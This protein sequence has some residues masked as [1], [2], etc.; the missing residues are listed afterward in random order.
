[1]AIQ[2]GLIGSE[3]GVRPYRVLGLH[4]QTD[5]EAFWTDAAVRQATAQFKK[6]QVD[7]ADPNSA[8][9]ATKHE[10]KQL[11]NE[12][13]Q[14]ADLRE[15]MEQAGQQTPSPEGQLE[16]LDELRSQRKQTD[17]TPSEIEQ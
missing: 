6:E 5:L 12:Q 14:R 17:N 11:H 2:A 4:E 7:N 1:M 8:G 15:S 13:E 3:Y 9:T 16:R 10:K